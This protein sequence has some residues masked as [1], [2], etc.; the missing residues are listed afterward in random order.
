LPRG[1]PIASRPVTAGPP[2]ILPDPHPHP[3][4]LVIGQED[5]T[6]PG[7]NYVSKEVRR[8]LGQYPKLG[9]AAARDIPGARLVELPGVGHIPHLE[10]PERFHRELLEF[11]GTGK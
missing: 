10:M 7:K 8:T 9:R 2:R 5:R 1:R 11:L 3:T 6:A 4:L